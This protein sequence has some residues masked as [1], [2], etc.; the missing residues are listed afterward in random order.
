MYLCCMK[1]II[2]KYKDKIYTQQGERSLRT[3]KSIAKE[4]GLTNAWIYKDHMGFF[5]I[6]YEP[7]DPYGKPEE[8]VA[9]IYRFCVRMVSRDSQ[10]NRDKK[11]KDLGI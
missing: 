4:A 11:L 8:E 1:E 7:I 9:S 10:L 6:N 2:E 5:Y 3:M